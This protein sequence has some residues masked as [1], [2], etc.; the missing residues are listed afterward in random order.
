[1]NPID[2]ICNNISAF[3]L[4]GSQER[5]AF[6][7]TLKLSDK[8]RK[9][10]TFYEKGGHLSPYMVGLLPGLLD[11][12]LVS[13]IS[14]DEFKALILSKFPD[15]AKLLNLPHQMETRRLAKLKEH[16]LHTP[17]GGALDERGRKAFAELVPTFRDLVLLVS[18]IPNDGWDRFLNRFK[19][20]DDSKPELGYEILTEI[21]MDILYGADGALVWLID[22]LV[23]YE[24]W[25]QSC[26]PWDRQNPCISC[27]FKHE[28]DVD[29]VKVLLSSI[30]NTVFEDV[31]EELCTDVE[32]C[33]EMVW[34]NFC[35][36]Q[37]KPRGYCPFGVNTDHII[38]RSTNV[39]SLR[40]NVAEAKAIS[41]ARMFDDCW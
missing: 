21:I 2:Y 32:E 16:L 34:A 1:M 23:D 5:K 9:S 22:A 38:R 29:K 11:S 18:Y 37:L 3:N 7:D 12:S 25:H 31:P 33:T 6:L 14:V 13:S 8:A 15:L 35:E 19:K 10:L 36:K 28:D 40:K 20:W 17:I 41:N 26:D 27:P 24:R 39:A 30:I 4:L